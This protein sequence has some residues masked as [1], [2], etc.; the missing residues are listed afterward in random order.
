MGRFSHGSTLPKGRLK[1]GFPKEEW[2]INY[3]RQAFD[4]RT[5]KDATQGADPSL[6]G[7]R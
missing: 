5:W 7:D 3:E 4:G 6:M 1:I 2:S